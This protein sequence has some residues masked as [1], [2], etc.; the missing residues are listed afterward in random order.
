MQLAVLQLL[1]KRVVIGQ[2]ELD[3]FDIAG[4]VLIDDDLDGLRFL[5]LFFLFF[6]LFFFGRLLFVLFRLDHLGDHDGLALVIRVQLK[7]GG[8]PV[9]GSHHIRAGD[10]GRMAVVARFRVK[11]RPSQK[12]RREDRLPGIGIIRIGNE[13]TRAVIIDPAS[14]RNHRNRV[15]HAQQQTDLKEIGKKVSIQRDHKGEVIRNFHTLQITSLAANISVITEN[16]LGT[17]DFAADLLNLRRHHQQ[18]GERIIPC[19]NLRTV[20]IIQIIREL[21]KIAVIAVSI[22]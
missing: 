2:R 20:G 9:I 12:L 6:P 11:N 16:M 3:F 19:R 22:L 18:H 1:H 17:V 5:L 10:H 4:V 7:V 13:T 15:G 14:R 8:N 21:H